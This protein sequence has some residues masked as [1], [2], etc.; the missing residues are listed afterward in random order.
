MPHP[1]FGH[2]PRKREKEPVGDQSQRN[3][4]ITGSPLSFSRQREKVARS[5]G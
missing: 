4:Q 2:L 3:Q 5:A 1:P